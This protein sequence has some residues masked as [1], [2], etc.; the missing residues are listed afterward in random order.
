ME[1]VTGHE[2]D[3]EKGLKKEPG[4]KCYLAVVVA[5]EILCLAGRMGQVPILGRGGRERGWE[6][7]MDAPGRE[8]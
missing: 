2:R 3:P 5:L 1:K 6:R 4:G 8:S 7:S